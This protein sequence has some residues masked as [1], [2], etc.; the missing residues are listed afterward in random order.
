MRKQYPTQYVTCAVCGKRYAGKIPKGGD[1]SALYPRM[2]YQYI[3]YIDPAMG[4][5]GNKPPTKIV[6]DGSYR[7]AKEYDE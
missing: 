6:C 3:P 5:M 2:H 1:G 7:E 4:I